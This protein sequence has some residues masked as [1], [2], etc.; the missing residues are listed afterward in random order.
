MA[1]N[2]PFV[3]T[4]RTSP[5]RRSHAGRIARSR[6]PSLFH[7]RKSKPPRSTGRRE[8]RRFTRPRANRPVENMGER[9]LT[10][11]VPQ[12]YTTEDWDARRCEGRRVQLTDKVTDFRFPPAEM[13]VPQPPT[14]R[15]R[16]SRLSRTATTSQEH[17]Q[18]PVGADASSSHPMQRLEVPVP[19]Q[20]HVS[21]ETRS[22]TRHWS[23]SNWDS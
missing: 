23:L 1:Q 21:Q 6:R 14:P 13:A 15:Q 5:R 3:R 20:P 11:T 22:V 9:T 2:A 16:V 8:G 17:T 4:D 19:I 7:K 12:P 18:R 10:A